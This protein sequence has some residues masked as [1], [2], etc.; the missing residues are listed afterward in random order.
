[1]LV[2]TLVDLGVGGGQGNTL[3][4]LCSYNQNK[5]RELLWSDFRSR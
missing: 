3:L 2:E 1:M 5:A 4:Q